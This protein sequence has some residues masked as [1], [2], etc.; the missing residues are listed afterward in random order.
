MWRGR[1]L[2]LR[3]L[4]WSMCALV[5]AGVVGCGESDDGARD[6]SAVP[7]GDVVA[8]GTSWTRIEDQGGVFGTRDEANVRLSDVVAGGPGYVAVGAFGQGRHGEGGTVAAV[9]TSVDGAAWERVAHDDEVFGAFGMGRLTGASAVTTGGPGLVAVGIEDRGEALVALAWVS[10][11]GRSWTR[12]EVDDP[13]ERGATDLDLRAIVDTDDGLVAVGIERG[14]PAGAPEYLA[15]WGSADGVDWTPIGLTPEE[16]A[17]AWGFLSTV[18]SHDGE[19]VAAGATDGPDGQRWVATVWHGNG[20]HGL[21][22]IPHDNEVFGGPGMPWIHGLATGGPGLVAVGTTHS[23]HLDDPQW[24]PAAV[25]TSPDGA[26][27]ERVAHDDEVFGDDDSATMYDVVASEWGLIAVGQRVPGRD[28]PAQMRFIGTVWTS[29]DGLAWTRLVE[30][31]GTFSGDGHTS[32]IAIT[33]GP[34]GLVAVG[35]V[36]AGEG[37]T[38]GAVWTSP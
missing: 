35:E 10:T 4:V 12:I 6:P 26:A 15:A 19:V 9:W 3:V 28:D 8:D 32:L 7:V 20:T 33:A 17:A 14:G 30:E 13:R 11:D 27:W 1:R 18:A 22:R 31:D 36:G 37:S 34:H 5:W 16:D 2:G 29:P 21:T 25:W 23:H 38:I 24:S